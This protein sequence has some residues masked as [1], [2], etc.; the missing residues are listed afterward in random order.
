MKNLTDIDYLMG[1]ALEEADKA[2][3]IDEVPIGAIICDSSGKI[4]SQAHNIKETN[5]NPCGHAEILAIQEASKKLNSWRLEDCTLIVTLEPCVMCMGALWQSRI[6]KLIFGAYDQKGGAISLGYKVY[7][8][9]RLNHRFPV[10]GGVC[11]FECSRVLSRFFREK[12]GSYKVKT[13][14]KDNI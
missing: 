12:R 5:N 1:L 6:K 2:Y 11:H 7:D 3:K 10:M 13:N 4:I 8:D 9:S 14:Y